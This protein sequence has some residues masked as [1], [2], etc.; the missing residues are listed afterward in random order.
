MGVVLVNEL[1]IGLIFAVIGY[2]IGT[3]KEKLVQ[4][5]RDYM[6]SHQQPQGA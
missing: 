4:K 3:N 5:S 6:K 2:K 1:A